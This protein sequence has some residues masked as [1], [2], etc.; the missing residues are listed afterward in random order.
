MQ[1]RP[2]LLGEHLP[3]A[4]PRLAPLQPVPRRLAKTAEEIATAMDAA[5]MAAEIEIP[6]APRLT[7]DDVTPAQA[8]TLLYENGGRLAIL[9]AEG[10]FFE[11]IM[12]RYSNGKP[13]LELI[14]KG[15]AGDRLV[16]D[17]RGLEEFVERPSL[18]LGICIQPQLLQDIAAKKQMTGRGL[19]PA[20]CY[21]SRPTAS[22]LGT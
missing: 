16:V 2:V 18:T 4:L 7:A 8:S 22:A 15:H 19:W 9:S 17:R 14:L 6:R 10:T 21:R 11:Q 20:C 5:Q 12:G 13:D 1:T 3:R